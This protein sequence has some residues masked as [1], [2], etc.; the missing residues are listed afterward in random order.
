M[1]APSHEGLRD[2]TVPPPPGRSWRVALT[3]QRVWP[4][5]RFVLGIGILA[6]AL[7]ALSGHTGELSGFSAVFGNLKWWWIPPAL[8][9]ELAS[10][11]CF[12]GLQYEFLRC[13]GLFPPEGSLLKMTFASQAIT[14]S[15]P[16]GTAF[17]AVYGFRWFRRFGADDTLA[18]WSLAGTVV[19]SVV[20]L[21]LVATAGLALATGEGASLDLIPVIVGVFVI[22][23]AIGVLFV[24]ERPLAT[25][26]TWGIRVSRKLIG[27]PRGDLAAEIERIVGMVTAV[28]LRPRQIITIV[29]W[30]LANWLFDCSCFAM[31]FLAV[32]ATIPWKGLL[33]AYGAGQLA[34]TLPFTPGGLGVVEGSITIALAEFGGPQHASTL[35]AVLMYRVISFWLVLLVGWGL[36]AQL[37]VQVRRGRWTRLALDAPVEAELVPEG[38]AEPGST[39]SVQPIPAVER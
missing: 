12:A 33:L 19:A 15:F 8:V 31:M 18:A 17:S 16:G 20:S 3:R 26:V 14:N 21:A 5:V 32:N 34:A 13:G 35:D 27:R 29:L 25:V 39:G 9:V 6:V 1:T 24:Y 2:E 28:R 37:A 38:P 11:V 10:F 22:T 7:W 36:W 4:A 23:L 30:G